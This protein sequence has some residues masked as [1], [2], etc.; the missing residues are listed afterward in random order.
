[1]KSTPKASQENIDRAKEYVIKAIQTRN[2]EI[3]VK[4]V[5]GGFPIDEPL[6][7]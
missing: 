4:I 6:V 7:E 1:M 2:V 3:L 5:D